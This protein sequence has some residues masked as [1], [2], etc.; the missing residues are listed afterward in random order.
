[1]RTIG[2]KV[3]NELFTECETVREAEGI[4]RTDYAL[5]AF[6]LYNSFFHFRRFSNPIEPASENGEP[7][8]KGRTQVSMDAGYRG[9]DNSSNG[10]G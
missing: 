8:D 9:E 10:R 3:P 4:N 1:L 7:D 2:A 5:N 6:R